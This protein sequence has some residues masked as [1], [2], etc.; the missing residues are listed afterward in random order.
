MKEPTVSVELTQEECKRI[1][2]S[3]LVLYGRVLTVEKVATAAAM[4]NLSSPDAW[5]TPE[6]K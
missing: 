5:L 1:V 2:T 3:L 6:K 4:F